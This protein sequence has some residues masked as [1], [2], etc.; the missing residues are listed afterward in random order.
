MH[1]SN[2]AIYF[3][4]YSTTMSLRK[5]QLG[6]GC[7][8]IRNELKERSLHSILDIWK[9]RNTLLIFDITFQSVVGSS[10]RVCELSYCVYGIRRAT[11]WKRLWIDKY[12]VELVNVRELYH[13]KHHNSST[14]Y[15]QPSYSLRNRLTLKYSSI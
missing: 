4:T 9:R 5:K 3:S 11:V 6:H 12:R 15:H 1:I 14:A 2:K 13:A 8:S 7:L 10:G